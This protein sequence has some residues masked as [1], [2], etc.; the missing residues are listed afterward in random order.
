MISVWPVR[1]GV[2]VDRGIAYCCAGLFPNEGVFVSALDAR[3]GSA[4]WVTRTSQASPQGYLLT[5]DQ[6][7]LVPT[8]RTAPALFRRRDGAHVGQYDVQGG[9]FALVADEVLISGPGRTTGSVDIADAKTR[10]RIASFNGLNMV[11]N[12]GFAYLHSL[13]S[14]AAMDRVRYLSLAR[15]K[16]AL[17]SRKGQLERR[18]SAAKAK[19]DR[20]QTRTL[21]S[22]LSKTRERL[23][24][25]P[26]EMRECFV[27]QRPC[28]HPYSCILVGETL[29]VGG[30]NEVVAFNTADGSELWMGRVD[31]RAYGLAVADGRLFVSTDQGAIH[32][33]ISGDLTP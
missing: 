22:E 15:E 26:R 7:L 28:R 31:G 10:E 17:D 14:I 30:D 8:G 13:T 16:K 5:S 24:I 11:V 9:S 4:L 19:G 23:T 27:W 1:T 6:Y 21:S 25:L 20:E 32:C 18:L 3:D 33:F 29:L 12:Q 2:L